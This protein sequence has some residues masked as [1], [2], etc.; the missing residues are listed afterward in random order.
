MSQH[1]KIAPTAMLSA[2]T[3]DPTK[4]Q[5]SL[6]RSLSDDE[7]QVLTKLM[8]RFAKTASAANYVLCSSDGE[9]ECLTPG[10]V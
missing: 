10:L 1:G 7:R 6:M 5:Q 8:W 3:D 2:D 9:D 4:R